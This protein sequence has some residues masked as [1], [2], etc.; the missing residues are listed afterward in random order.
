MTSPFTVQGPS[1]PGTDQIIVSADG[2]TLAVPALVLR[3]RTAAPPQIAQQIGTPLYQDPTTGQPA[4]L[5]QFGTPLPMA[6]GTADVIAADNAMAAWAFDPAQ[7]D[8]ATN[9]TSGSVV[10]SS[11]RLTWPKLITQI[12]TIITIAGATLTAGQ[13]F[14]G[15][16]NSLGQLLG[17]TADLTIPFAT[18]QYLASAL[19]TPVMCP[20]ARYYVAQLSNGTT[21]P[22]LMTGFQTSVNGVNVGNVGLATGVSRFLVG[23]TLQTTLPATINLGA[24]SP[25]G[26]PRWAAII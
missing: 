13:N 23:P 14:M 10:L 2:A 16:Y 11:V 21:T 4:F 18:A 22:T 3:S 7:G 15:L 17:I 19:T 26:S 20:A 9:A 12:A 5:D 1:A 6:A 8:G 24:Q 25:A